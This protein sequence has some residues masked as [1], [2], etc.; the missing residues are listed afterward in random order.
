MARMEGINLGDQDKLF[1]IYR[2]GVFF[3]AVRIHPRELNSRILA[4]QEAGRRGAKAG[5]EVTIKEAPTI[6]FEL[7]MHRLRTGR[8]DAK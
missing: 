7:A 8:P 5:T 4:L 2:D 6:P 1:A 3:G